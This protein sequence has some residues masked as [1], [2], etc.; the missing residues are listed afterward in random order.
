MFSRL[1]KKLKNKRLEK[2]LTNL[3]NE[4][5]LL[6][7]ESKLGCKIKN[8][9]LFIQALIHR[10]Y[11][12]DSAE[13]TVPNERL[14]FLGD[15]V[16][17]LLVAEYLYTHF[18]EKN[19]G[20][21]T[22][23]R[24]KIVNRSALANAAENLDLADFIIIGKNLI[25]SFKNGSKTV[26]SDAFEAIVGAIYLD[27]GI[28]EVN[29]FIN[30]YLIKPVT[31]ED[32]FLTDENYKSQLLEYAQSKKMDN[33]VYSVVSEDGPQHS[34]I[35]TIKVTIDDIEFGRGQGKNKKSAEQDAAKAAMIKMMEEN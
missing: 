20:F 16:L 32:D 2:S 5:K 8:K 23:V 28:K 12:E 35:F 33:P 10:S 31:K 29:K 24:A 7:L 1:V 17:N 3:I 30:K 34:R 25:Q 6:G 14:E 27:S 19:E 13:H 21:L 15:A 26:L 18:P 4:D 22:K 11:L 9:N